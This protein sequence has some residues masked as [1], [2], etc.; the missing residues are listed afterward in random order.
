[1]GATGGAEV[2][3]VLLGL[4]RGAVGVEESVAVAFSGL[5]RFC[6][7]RSQLSTQRGTERTD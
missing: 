5:D 6:L 3:A 7:Q 4:L 2:E 1:M